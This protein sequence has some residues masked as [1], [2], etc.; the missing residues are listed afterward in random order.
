[1]NLE[2][3]K[4]KMNFRR[5][6]RKRQRQVED[7]GKDVDDSINHHFFRRLGNLLAVKRFLIGWIALICLLIFGVFLQ[8]SYM[9]GQFQ[10]TVFVDGGIFSEGIVGSYSN[11]NPIYASGSVDSAVS[12]LV[13]A[14]LFRY[15][16]N[17]TL[18]PDLAKDIEVDLAETT[19][20]VTLKDNLYW[21]DGQRLTAKDVA[22]TY[23]TVKQ[24]EAESYLS[25]GW[26]GINVEAIDDKTVVFKLDNALSPFPH[27]LT[28]GIIPEHILKDVPLNKLRSSDFNT[29]QL[30]GSG[31]FKLNSV[32]LDNTNSSEIKQQ[33]VGLLA[34]DKYHRGQPK[35]NRYVIKTYQ[36]QSALEKGFNNKKIQAIGGLS[37]VPDNVIQDTKNDIY[38]AP[39]SAQTMVF[40]KN[41]SGVLKNSKVRQALVLGADRKK[42]I[43]AVG[44][45][46]KINDSP[47]LSLQTGYD[48]KFVQNT[49]NQ[50]KSKAIL[51][52]DGW[53][54]DPIS[55]IRTK[56]KKTLE[57]RLFA[58]S[59][60]ENRAVTQALSE[61][62]KAIG[63]NLIVELQSQEELTATLSSHNYDALLYT[64]STGADPD[65]FAY[66]HSSQADIRSS[67]RLNFS[68]YISKTADVALTGG[69]SRSDPA[70]RAVKYQPFL[71][72][73]LADNPA[74]ALYQPNYTFVVR[75]PF[76]GFNTKN[77]I[78][79]TDRY[80]DVESWM[81]RQEKIL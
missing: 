79:P 2:R 56:A 75:S 53:K 11:A 15:D 13:F 33:Q 12:K 30:I 8:F 49:S 42:V 50:Q 58:E 7:I 47:L 63:V 26:Q 48:K 35:L 60:D 6:A 34:F 62:W 3:R 73:W 27:S 69:R 67:R 5:F 70:I 57:F 24:P 38:K 52:K 80:A 1:M 64:I 25:P 9:R 29:T 68:E 10:R 22:F 36:D 20:T 4:I 77:L 51:D 21:H 40:F 28:T 78:S 59:S 18:M 45:P 74:L 46:L 72:A 16:S 55:G 66:W 19:Y 32:E 17:G 39:L 23:N 54:F 14:G 31:P 81:I 61:Q 37:K 71:K 44:E 65:V 43:S 76:S 41:S